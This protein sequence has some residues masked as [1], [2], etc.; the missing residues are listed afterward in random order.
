MRSS[1][2]CAWS[3]VCWNWAWGAFSDEE[4]LAKSARHVALFRHRSR[5]DRFE[6]VHRQR[7][8]FFINLTIAPMNGGGAARLQYCNEPGD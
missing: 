5:P 6:W 7:W 8:E 2:R 3:I 4:S 1:R